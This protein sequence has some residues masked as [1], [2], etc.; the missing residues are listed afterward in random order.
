MEDEQATINAAHL[1]LEVTVLSLKICE[2]EVS[3]ML[4]VFRSPK[5]EGIV[6]V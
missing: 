3:K 4:I 5:R 1:R 6:Y 2:H